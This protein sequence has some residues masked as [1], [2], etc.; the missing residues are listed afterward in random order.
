MG[1]TFD[2]SM[3]EKIAKR[4]GFGD[5]LADGVEVAA[6]KIGKG[7]EQYAMHVCGQ[8]LPMLDPKL[9]TRRGYELGVVYVADAAPALG[10]CSS[11]GWMARKAGGLSS[12][13]SFLKAV[14]GWDMTE[15]DF[16]VVSDRIATLR[17]AFNVR[18]GFKPS[19][20]R[21][22]DRVLGKHPHRSGPLKGITLDLEPCIKEHSKSMGRDY[23]TG[24]PTPERLEELGLD[25]VIKDLY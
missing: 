2:Q 11:V 21:L 24:K 6:M 12:L 8:E 1:L 20:F 4:E 17:Q 14:T 25:D 10:V 5:V 15:K 18:E 9:L 22:P 23:A 16:L 7:S 19:D 13:Y 3:T